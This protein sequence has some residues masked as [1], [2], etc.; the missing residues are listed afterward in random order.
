MIK[1][2]DRQVRCWL[3]VSF[4]HNAFWKPGYGYTKSLDEAG[5]YTFN[6]AKQ[7]CEQANMAQPADDP[8]EVMVCDPRYAP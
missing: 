3:I 6:E 7:I 1:H 8:H 5:R 2:H 4:E